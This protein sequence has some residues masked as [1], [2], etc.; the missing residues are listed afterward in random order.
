HGARNFC[1]HGFKVETSP[2][3]DP[4]KSLQEGKHPGQE[5]YSKQIL[6]IR[7][8]HTR[9][10]QV[11]AFHNGRGA[12]ENL[13]GGLKSQCQMDY[14]PVRTLAGNQTYLIC[15][16]LAHN[17]ARELQMVADPPLRHTTEK[18]APLWIFQE[19]NTLRRHLIQRAGRFSWPQGRLTLT[20]GLNDTVRA[21]LLH[22]LGALG[23]Q[24]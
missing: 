10:K 6:K 11:V 16:I 8:K 22:Y 18:R 1:R 3:Q 13:F 2:G 15:A 24:A 5:I 23:Y 21:T 17:L 12:Q 7:G 14:V 20:L 19:L 9:M 4:R